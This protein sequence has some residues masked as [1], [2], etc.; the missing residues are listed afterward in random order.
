MANGVVSENDMCIRA[1]L[2]MNLSNKIFP[3]QNAEFKSSM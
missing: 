1:N 2:I 3:Q